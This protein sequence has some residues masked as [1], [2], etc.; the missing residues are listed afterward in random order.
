MPTFIFTC[1]IKKDLKSLLYISACLLDII[2]VFDEAGPLEEMVESVDT[3]YRLEK[4]ISEAFQV[5]TLV[6]FF[7]N[8]IHTTKD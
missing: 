2:S 4:Y 8:K 1:T 7:S 6:I 5:I 3:V